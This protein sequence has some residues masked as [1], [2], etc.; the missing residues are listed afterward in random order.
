MI[1]QKNESFFPVVKRAGLEKI[2]YHGLPFFSNIFQ[3]YQPRF[4]YIFPLKNEDSPL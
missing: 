4:L 3:L 1:L 2:I